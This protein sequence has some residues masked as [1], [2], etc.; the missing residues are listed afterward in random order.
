[1][2]GMFK[3]SPTAQLEKAHRDKLKEARDLQRGGDIR[4]YAAKMA[5]AEK[6]AA[7]LQELKAAKG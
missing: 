5:E 6:I 4:G 1:M 7:E 2:F 3:K